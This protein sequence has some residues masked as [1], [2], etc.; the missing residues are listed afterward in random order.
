MT[1]RK[2]LLTIAG[3]CAVLAFA[4]VG[5]RVF[6]GAS[7]ATRVK[8]TEAGRKVAPSVSTP[9]SAS[10]PQP[11]AT[12]QAS[13]NKLQYSLTDPSSLWVIVN[14]KRPLQPTSFVPPDLT[15]PDTAKRSSITSDER[16]LRQA[17]ATSLKTLFTAA[18]TDGITLNLQSGYRSYNL[19]TSVYNRWVTQKGQAVADTESARPG[20]SEHQT[21]LAADVGGISR[22]ACNVE[23][24]FADT[25]EGKWVATHAHEHGFVIR[26]PADQDTVTG[27]IYEPWHL[28]YVGPELAKQLHTEGAKTLEG[29][30]GL[31]A[32][33]SY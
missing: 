26:Y 28:R 24:C 27:F 6:G 25:S 31:G 17:A 22:P 15:V 23:P 16:Q 3:T 13:F 18:A 10:A 21:G 30:F 1:K 5:V 11:A 9:D 29:Y 2:L 7:A 33:P 12:T 32:A 4:I 20:H 14:K 8:P 19:Q